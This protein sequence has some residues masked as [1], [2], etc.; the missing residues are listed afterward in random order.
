MFGLFRKLVA[1][2]ISAAALMGGG[3][4]ASA[5]SLAVLPLSALEKHA[6]VTPGGS[7]GD[8]L[9]SL[10]LKKPERVEVREPVTHGVAELVADTG[11]SSEFSV[12]RGVRGTASTTD[13]ASRQNQADAVPDAQGTAFSGGSDGIV[14]VE[15]L[16]NGLVAETER[17]AD[18]APG[19]VSTNISGFV[20]ADA[21]ALATPAPSPSPAPAESSA[22]PLPQTAED[23]EDF[24]V[25]APSVPAPADFSK[26]KNFEP[27]RVAVQAQALSLGSSLGREFDLASD[28][29]PGYVQL[30]SGVYV[31]QEFLRFVRPSPPPLPSSGRSVAQTASS[32]SSSSSVL[33]RSRRSPNARSS[34]TASSSA[35]LALA[36]V[37]STLPYSSVAYSAQYPLYP[38]PNIVRIT[39]WYGDRIHPFTG[40][41]RLHSGVDF[42]V[43]VGTPVL[44]SLTGVVQFAGWMRGYGY[45]VILQHERGAVQSVQSL[46]AH[47]SAIH[48]RPG[49]EVLQGEM[50]ALSGNTGLSTGPHLHFE[51]RQWNGREWVPSDINQIVQYAQD[52]KAAAAGYQTAQRSSQSSFGSPHVMRVALQVDVPR[53]AV[54]ASESALITG[55]DGRHL[56][57]LPSLQS[58]LVQRDG[59][60]ILVNGQRLPAGFFIEPQG[61]GVFAINGRWYRGRLLVAIRP[62]GLIAVNWVDLETYLLSVVGS[63][64]YPS[65]DEDALQAQAIAARSYALVHRQRPHNP[66]WF[67]VFAT[68][69]HQA[70]RG[71]ERE[72]STTSHAVVA[73]Q[74]VVLTVGDRVVESLYAANQSIVDRVHRGNGMSQEGAADL[75][76]RGASFWQILQHYYPGTR[77]SRLY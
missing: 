50:I 55:F 61:G 25:P 51:L 46:Y 18:P 5:E 71:I 31:P 19:S 36:Y 48:V 52:L 17:S 3:E 74:G 23:F 34:V 29:P 73:T 39:S 15:P 8:K 11:S 30:S 47:L 33:T 10:S 43:P 53:F 1:V 22:P 49:Q 59:S 67:D 63:E 41:R 54:A 76:N 38:L 37:Q 77:L 44:A 69:R 21:G 45:T 32:S 58:I 70:Y 35:Q 60:S 62:G 66:E 7:S 57:T 72:F 20:N 27:V 75:A 2:C 4:I 42:G 68:E 56:A 26:N 16:E 6:A 28:I 40:R 9:D 65:W 13:A 14:S 12:F 24:N 64:V